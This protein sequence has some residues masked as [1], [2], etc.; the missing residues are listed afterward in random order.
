MARAVR[1]F[2]FADES[3][4][5]V[6]RPWRLAGSGAT[7]AVALLTLSCAGMEARAQAPR[8]SFNCA[9]ARTADE[10]TICGDARLAELD[11]TAAQGYARV[12][13][14]L[15]ENARTEAKELLAKRAKCG[16]DRLCILEQ[17]VG[18]I[19]TFSDLGAPVSVPP[20]VGAYRI[21]LVTAR[22]LPPEPGIPTQVGRCTVTKIAAIS[23]RFGNVLGAQ[24]SRVGNDEGTAVTF[25]NKG[26]GVSYS[27][28]RALAES[29]IG[30]DVLMCLVSIPQ[31]CPPGDDRGRIYSGTNL[32][33]KG[34]WQLSDSQHSCGGA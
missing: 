16:D 7:V 29:R 26:G 14:N 8:P 2:R 19:E 24:P 20:W 23:T 3:V 18:A 30:D 13:S 34:S 15:R 10:R 6:R 12:P 22:G 33:T 32:R 31:D 11:R 4:T 9:K 25:A 1:Q 28:V 27:Y 21:A 17:Q 5:I